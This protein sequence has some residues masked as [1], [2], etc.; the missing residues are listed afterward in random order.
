MAGKLAVVAEDDTSMLAIYHHV[1]DAAGFKVLAAQD[2]ALAI[3]LLDQNTPDVAFIDIR[4]PLVDGLEILDYIHNSPHLDNMR[5]IVISADK[6]AEQYTRHLDR[7]E[8]LLKPVYPA[9][10]RDLVMAM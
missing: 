3:K 6:N 9:V 7:V 4:L 2:G 5:V 10:I 8:F 1:L